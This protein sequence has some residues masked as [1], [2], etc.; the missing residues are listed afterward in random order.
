MIIKRGFTLIELLVVIAIIGLL[1]SVV[2]ASLR[3]ARD[4]ASDTSVKANL[5]TV[6]KQSAL[7]YNDNWNYTAFC[8]TVSSAMSAARTAGG[9]TGVNSPCNGASASWAASAALKTGGYWCVDWS[10]IAKYEASAIG[11]VT[12]CP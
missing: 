1:S 2:L 12:T 3:S 9:G 10:G 5:E 8:A 7:Y 11:S 6:R 4:K